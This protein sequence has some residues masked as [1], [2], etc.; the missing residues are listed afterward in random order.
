MSAPTGL[1]GW[2]R[3]VEARDASLLDELLAD[4][5]VFRSPA[6]HTPQEG[7]A[8]TTAYLAAALAVLGPT[9]TYRH[10]WADS[11]SAVLEFE[12]EIDGLV[13]H[14]VDMLRWNDEGRLTGF[15][16]MVRPYKALTRLMERMVAELA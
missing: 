3:V 16:V 1:A 9:L 4:D 15:T 2:H 8:L 6:V 5:C 10:E 14:G 12:A 13:V 11:S 7:K